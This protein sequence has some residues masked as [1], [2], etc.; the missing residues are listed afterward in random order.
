MNHMLRSRSLLVLVHRWA[1]LTMAVFLVVVGITGSLL[2]WLDELDVLISPQLRVAAPPT[3]NA[4]PINPLLLREAVLAQVPGARVH[5]VP[6]Q[7]EPGR[8]V[9]F[10][11]SAD[12]PLP[13]DEVFVDP[14]TARV[15]GERMWGDITQGLQ[16]LMPFIYRLHYALALGSAGFTLLGIVAL[17]WTIDCFVGLWLTLPARRRATAYPVAA[18][19]AHGKSWWARWWPAWKVR[20]HGRAYKLNFDLHRAGGLWLWAMMFVLAWSSVAFNLSEVYAPVTRLLLSQQQAQPDRSHLAAL[21]RSQHAPAIPHQAAREIGRRLMMEQAGLRGFTVEREEYIGYDPR[22][23]VYTYMVRSSRDVRERQGGNT[24]IFFDANTGAFRG[25]YLPTGEAAGDTFTA[26]ITS[27][28]MAGMWGWP[29][30]LLVCA[31]GV[32][33]TVLSGTGVYLWWKKHGARRSA[34]IARSPPRSL[35][36][37]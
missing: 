31:L 16:N 36:T 17:A 34:V 15:L 8:S 32:A 23:A 3:P 7:V 5:W 33:L 11:V 28:H 18:R 12:V 1:G 29:L 21:S 20:W 13:Y 4:Q 19:A 6:L 24:R 10:H 37:D 30:Q 25:I 22:R 27:L 35:M 9:R 26:W 2:A 14:Y